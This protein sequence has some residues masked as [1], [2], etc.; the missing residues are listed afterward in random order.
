MS[1]YCVHADVE[2]LLPFL[3]AF[4]AS[5][6]PSDT[7]VDTYIV[8]IDGEMRGVIEAAGYGSA[9]TDTT[10]IAVLKS[11]CAYG[12]AARVLLANRGVEPV[13][14]DAYRKLYD[15]GLAKIRRGEVSGLAVATA[16]VALP[17]SG[18]TAAPT[19]YNEPRFKFGVTQW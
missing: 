16:T 17:R 4:S 1:T 13:Q 15:D 12:T 7:Q 2:A 10:A 11:Y 8:E 3:G 19:T 9:P 5:T 6:K 14:A 18:Y